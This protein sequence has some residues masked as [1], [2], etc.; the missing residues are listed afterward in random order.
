MPNSRVPGRV[1]PRQAHPRIFAELL[2]AQRNAVF[3]LVELEYLGFDFV[4]DRQHFRRMLDAAPGEIGDV[5]QAVDAAQVHER[6]VIG[7]VLDDA[8]DHCAF[9]Q[10]G[11]QRLALGALRRFQHCAARYHHVVALAVELDDLEI[12]LLVFVGRG[13]LD[14]ADI[15]Q[16]TRQEGADAVHH[17]SET[18]L[19]LAVDHALHE[20][21]LFERLL[22]D[23]CQAARRFALSR[24]SRVSP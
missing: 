6:A 2:H 4:A 12:H 5:Q 23:S 22:R 24:D 8:L 20:R 17:D 19:D 9:L 21:A 10:A 15:H 18:A 13:V 16:R 1:A 3:L 7:D 11:E 14:R